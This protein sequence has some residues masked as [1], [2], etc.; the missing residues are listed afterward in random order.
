M[1]AVEPSQEF[2]PCSQSPVGGCITQPTKLR[3]VKPIY[4][5]SKSDAGIGGTVIVDARIG[6]DGFMKNFS[7]VSG[8]RDFA[9][10]AIEAFTGWR[11]SQTRI[12]GVPVEVDM[13]VTT[14][15]V[16]K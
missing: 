4:P 10:A 7:V 6:T 14:V 12:D 2:D 11:F 9:A 5:P 15:F 13:R 16:P 1:S 8:D 3:D